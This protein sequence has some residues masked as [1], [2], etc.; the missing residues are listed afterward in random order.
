MRPPPSSQPTP[1]QRQRANIARGVSTP[2]PQKR[3]RSLSA[4][5]RRKV[6]IELA[7]S[8]GGQS[9][10]P[11]QKPQASAD[12]LPQFKPGDESEDDCFTTS[13]SPPRR[14]VALY[15]EEPTRKKLRTD[16]GGFE[17]G[18][19]YMFMTPPMSDGKV[20]RTGFTSSQPESPTRGKG[21]G[22]DMNQWE[23]IR[24]DESHPY[25]QCAASLQS[26]PSS[27]TASPTSASLSNTTP[28]SIKTLLCDMSAI[29]PAYIA[30][31][32]RKQGAM[33]KSD[34]FKLQRIK[35]LE[36]EN[37]SCVLAYMLISLR[38]SSGL[39][40]FAVDCATASGYLK[41]QFQL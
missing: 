27:Q 17:S 8:E 4:S 12:S 18:S 3:P 37:T 13:S 33:E 32:E 19:G 6:N 35:K 36:E 30:K 24:A 15:I 22:E 20:V 29:L 34:S 7:L 26:K 25:H 14:A 11:A 28:E 10:Q 31:L 40:L 38:Y 16:N 5:E 21:K 23:K 39:F 41:R 9:S 2:S 1:S